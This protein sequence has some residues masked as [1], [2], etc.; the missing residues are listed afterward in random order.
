MKVLHLSSEKTWRGGEQQIAYLIEELEKLGVENYVACREGSAFQDHCKQHLIEHVALPF[1]NN[2]DVITAWQIR[3]FCTYMKIDIVHMHSSRSHTM[4]VIASLLG[5]NVKLF[6]SRRVDFPSAGN[7]FS[8][9]KYN[10]KGIKKILCVSEKIKEVIAPTIENKRKLEVVYSGIDTSRFEGKTNTGILHREYTLPDDTKIVANISAIAP[11]KDYF[12]FVDT[13]ASFQQNSTEK[14]KFFII[15]EGECRNEI[16]EYIKQ[17]NLTHDIIL[18]GFRHDIADV[19][20]EIDVFLMTS[21]EEG[22]G[23]TVLDAFANKI[24]VVA[25]AGGGIPEMVKHE[26]TGL[27]YSIGDSKGLARGIET[28]LNDAPMREKLTKNATKLL[29]EKFTK[30]KTAAQTLEQYRNAI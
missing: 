22:L 27:L 29:M 5:A 16:E 30:E 28:M 8:N 6:L 24:P 3:N 13:V 25:T 2:F 18:T 15:G 10:Y 20:P 14:V 21:K 11:H 17:K 19:L 23:T 4:G 9:Y 12:T 1:A 7:W 26:H